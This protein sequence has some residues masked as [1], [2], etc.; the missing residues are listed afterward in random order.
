MWYDALTM[1]VKIINTHKHEYFWDHPQRYLAAALLAF[2]CFVNSSCSSY[3]LNYIAQ[4]EVSSVK[5]GDQLTPKNA[6]DD[7]PSQAS[8]PIAKNI[9]SYRYGANY[10]TGLLPYGCA[11]TFWLY[12][13]FCWIYLGTPFADDLLDIEER[14]ASNLQIL[15]AGRD[16]SIQ[17]VD[18]EKVEQTREQPYYLLI[19]RD[20]SILAKGYAPAKSA[21]ADVFKD[22]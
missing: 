8:A 15:F 5:D 20:G 2:C 19:D 14:A 6:Q 4:I 3:R 18:Y 22:S 21:L 10:S 7:E 1:Q 17:E 12:G 11:A 9:Y 16:Y 13:G